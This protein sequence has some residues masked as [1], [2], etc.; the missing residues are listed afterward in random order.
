ML[1]RS[2]AALWLGLLVGNL[3]LIWPV[4]Q[5]WPATWVHDEAYV[6]LGAQRWLRGEWP[7]RDWLTHLSPGSYCLTVPWFWLWG[8]GQLGTRSLMGLVAALQG[9]LVWQLARPLRGPDRVLA[10]MCWAVLGLLEIPILNYHWFSVLWYS[11]AVVCARAWVEG[12]RW[13]AAGVGAAIALSG[14]TLQSEGLAGVLFLAAVWLLWRPAG[15]GRA[16]GSLLA[17]SLVLWSPFLPWAGL[18]LEQ[19]VLFMTGH[20]KS[21]T[22]AY[23]WSELSPSLEAARLSSWNADPVGFS[24]AWLLVFWRGLKYNALPLLVA[25]AFWRTRRAEQRPQQVVLVGLLLLAMANLNRQTLHYCAY[26]LPLGFPCMIWELS[27]WPGFRRWRW[28]LFGLLV[29]FWGLQARLFQRDNLWAVET[30]AGR[31]WSDDRNQRLAHQLLGSWLETARQA[32]QEVVCWPYLPALYSLW[33]MPNPLPEPVLY[34]TE[35][36]LEEARRA[37]QILAQ[38]KVDWMIFIPV[39]G[40]TAARERKIR[41]NE[42]DALQRE[43]YQ[44][45]TQDYGL[46]QQ[47]SI[48]QLLRR[49]PT[50]GERP[51]TS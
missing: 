47:V 33:R 22:F 19:N 46:A 40:A 8:D 16:L 18:V 23:S 25:L 21:N 6:V 15:L 35:V 26:L 9:L 50:A 29:A 10:W 31:Y 34:P 1:S 17:T 48:L 32:G 49:R 41:A 13:A 51:G 3:L 7:Y 2:R 28:L 39:D 24:Y 45:L 11:L 44:V 38:K 5:N 30:P 14:W 42:F 20:Q 4:Y 36:G 43:F 12:R 27:H 37:A